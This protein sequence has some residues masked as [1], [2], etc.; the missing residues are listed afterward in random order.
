LRDRANQLAALSESTGIDARKIAYAAI[1]Q[2][3][4]KPELWPVIQAN[5]G[6]F[7]LSVIAACE[8]GLDFSKPNEVHLV[9]YRGK[10]PKITLQR[11]YK[12]WAKLARRS[13]GV[14]DVDFFAVFEN[15]HYERSRGAV[16]AVT[17][18]PTRFGQERGALIGFCAY[19]VLN[20]G[21]VKF[22]EMTVPE[23]EAHAAQYT[24]AADFGPFAGIEK[25]GA[26]H[27][28]F[29]IYGLK[30]VIIRLCGRQLDLSSDVGAAIEQEFEPERQEI[31]AAVSGAAMPAV[32]IDIPE[33]ETLDVLRL[34]LGSLRGKEI[35]S[36]ATD[37]LS[38]YLEQNAERITI[39]ERD[40][41][42]Q[43]IFDRGEPVK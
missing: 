13:D 1:T 41:V 2:I 15:D 17:F 40:A 34:T 10:S 29:I 18:E 20:G 9:P 36:V 8:Q 43:V 32:T 3:Q 38:S 22:E 25:Q 39:P 7:V 35:A 31:A 21:R 14:L 12:G 26:N 16:Q 19:A 11:G 6:S 5:P 24:K 37:E 42:M 4:G 33:E 23:V 27:P 28:R 30:T